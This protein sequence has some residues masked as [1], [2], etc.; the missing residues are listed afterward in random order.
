MGH[1]ELTVLEGSIKCLMLDDYKD[2]GGGGWGVGGGGWGCRLYM[3][4]CSSACDPYYSV[5][6]MRPMASQITGVSIVY[7]SVCWGADKRKHQ[8]SAS[9]ASARGIYR[10]PVNSPH[11]G[12]VTRKMF[13]LD[14]VIML[15]RWLVVIHVQLT[16]LH[17]FAM[18]WGT[19][20]KGA[21]RWRTTRKRG[22]SLSG[23]WMDHLLNY[24]LSSG[25]GGAMLPNNPRGLNGPLTSHFI[26]S[27]HMYFSLNTPL[28]Y[29]SPM[30]N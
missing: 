3:G 28:Y 20:S 30:P 18:R 5:V 6:I 17:N 24:S 23:R 13:P 21:S 12:P 2:D 22:S 27:Y 1:I 16:K 8:S 25:H 11:K 14:D 26:F 7:S 10:W 29:W 4:V 15:C 9:L 19:A